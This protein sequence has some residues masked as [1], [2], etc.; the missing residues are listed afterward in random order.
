MTYGKK[1][2][3]TTNTWTAAVASCAP[4]DRSWLEMNCV[5]IVGLKAAGKSEPCMDAGKRAGSWKWGL[6][7]A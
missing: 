1:L 5:H 6:P 7:S 4:E 2:I 3:I